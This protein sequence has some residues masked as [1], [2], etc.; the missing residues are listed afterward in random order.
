MATTTTGNQFMINTTAVNQ[1]QAQASCNALGMHLAAFQSPDEQVEVE[2]YFIQNGFLLPSFHKHYWIGM[3]TTKWPNFYWTDR[4]VS[5]SSYNGWGLSN[6]N[7]NPKPGTCAVASNALSKGSPVYWG[8]D[9]TNCDTTT[10]IFIC[11]RAMNVGTYY[12]S[13]KFSATYIFNSTMANFSDAEAF[14]RNS[15][16]HLVS[17][18]SQAEQAEVESFYINN[19]FMFPTYHRFYWMGLRAGNSIRPADLLAPFG[20]MWP[21]FTYIDGA[22]APGNGVYDHWGRYQ[23]LN[24]PEPDNRFSPELCAGGNASQSYGTPKAWGWADT[25]CNGSFPFICKLQRELPVSPC[26]GGC[27][28]AEATMPGQLLLRLGAA[29]GH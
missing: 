12:T 6:P 25:R 18:K 22:P 26:S 10:S 20:N 5:P 27:A 3:T 1:R 15:G 2:S 24:Y 17:W 9:D 14:C 7:Q 11:R 13:D 21:N 4:T 19:G 16:A 28:A 29:F 23:P 8:W